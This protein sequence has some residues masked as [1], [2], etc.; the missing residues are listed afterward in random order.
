MS[1]HR[2]PSKDVGS[3]PLPAPQHCKPGGEIRWAVGTPDGPRSQSW[4]LFGSTTDDDVYLGGPRSQTGAPAVRATRLI[5][6]F[7]RLVRQSRGT[8]S[9][10]LKPADLG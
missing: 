10:L 6:Q 1:A 3:D 2:A 5:P 7:Q 8:L 9:G 4:S